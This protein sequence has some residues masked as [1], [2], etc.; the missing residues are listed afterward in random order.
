MADAKEPEFSIRQIE[1]AIDAWIANGTGKELTAAQL[2][3]QLGGKKLRA[4]VDRID[5]TLS[6][7]DRF[8]DD[9]KGKY[10][11][12]ADFFR[13]YEF[14]VTPDAWEI[15]KGFLFPGHRFSAFINPEIFPSEIKLTGPDGKAVELETIQ[16]PVSQAFHHHLL[17]GSEQSFDFFTAE[18]AANAHLSRRPDPDGGLQRRQRQG[19]TAGSADRTGNRRIDHSH[20]THFARDGCNRFYLSKIEQMQRKRLFHIKTKPAKMN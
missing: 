4:L 13:G 9:G 11:L 16:L 6:G 18:S 2:I 10:T 8:F 12:R 14:L 7:D 15:E 20:P 5:R 1:E 3:R 17:L 19:E